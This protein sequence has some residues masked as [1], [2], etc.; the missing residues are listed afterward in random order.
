VTFP[1]FRYGGLSCG[2]RWQRAAEAVDYAVAT[3]GDHRVEQ[4]RGH[5]LTDDGYAGGVD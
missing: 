1:L 4:W 2:L 5:G 3:E